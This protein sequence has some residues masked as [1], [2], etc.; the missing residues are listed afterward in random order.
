MV[1]LN[2][3]FFHDQKLIAKGRKVEPRIAMPRQ[4]LTIC[5]RVTGSKLLEVGQQ[6]GGRFT[7]QQELL[8]ENVFCGALDA[9]GLDMSIASNTKPVC[10]RDAFQ[11]GTGEMVSRIASIANDTGGSLPTKCSLATCAGCSF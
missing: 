8:E 9:T 3:D 2:V 1:V 10:S 5:E 7:A 11:A 4:Q 6:L